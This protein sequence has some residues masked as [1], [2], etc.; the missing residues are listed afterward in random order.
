M[1][2]RGPLPLYSRRFFRV[3]KSR[4]LRHKRN[5]CGQAEAMA[6]IEWTPETP[7][8][9][10]AQAN[11]AGEFIDALR[12][13]NSHW[14]SD[15]QMP[16]VFRGH[17]DKTWPLLPSAWRPANGVIAACRAEATRRF[18]ASLPEQQLRWLLPPNFFTGAA[19]FGQEDA[20]LQ[21]Q[22]AIE[23]T[24]ELLS[25]WDFSLACDERGLSTPLAS[26]PPDPASQPN[27]LWDAG[28]PLV[29]DQ[30]SRFND[31]FPMLALAQH[32]ACPRAF[33]I[34]PSIQWLP[35]SLQLKIFPSVSLKRT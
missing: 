4:N 18:D 32:M 2:L 21:R 35:L 8:I 23:A 25:I 7:G 3:S 24:A 1:E 30:F 12:R 19:S 22:L 26:L 34:G 31:I 17:R 6:Q 13:S 16:W 9:E 14:W 28:A 29:A 5:R 11:S 20:S 27:W 10:T 15:G 33:S